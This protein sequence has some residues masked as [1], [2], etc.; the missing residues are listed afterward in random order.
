MFKIR[1]AL[2]YI[3]QLMVQQNYLHTPP[4]L[5]APNKRTD[6]DWAAIQRQVVRAETCA[7]D[8]Q[9]RIE[10]MRREIDRLRQEAIMSNYRKTAGQRKPTMMWLRRMLHGY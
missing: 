3:G 1:Q 2:Y 10:T 7:F 4:P 6:D 9:V 5:P 8:A